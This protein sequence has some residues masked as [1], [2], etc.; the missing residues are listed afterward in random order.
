[1]RVALLQPRPDRHAD[2][3]G[4]AWRRFEEPIPGGID[5][6]GSVEADIQGIVDAEKRADVDA[7]DRVI[8]GDAKIDDPVRRVGDG[9][10][11]VHHVCVHPAQLRGR[12]EPERG[13]V[14]SREEGLLRR[15]Q[16]S[17]VKDGDCDCWVNLP[18]NRII[19]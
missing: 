10:G 3:E 19:A 8:E 9:V 16:A 13:F 11:V 15:C 4:P 5:H 17:I 18:G 1:M 14:A 6:R 12:A 7:L 2:V